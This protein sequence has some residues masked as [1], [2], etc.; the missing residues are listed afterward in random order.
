M[1]TYAVEIDPNTVDWDEFN[2]EMAKYN[3]ELSLYCDKVAEELGVNYMAACDIVYLRGR[4]RWTQEKED[5]LIKLA[6]EGK[7]LPFYFEDFDVPI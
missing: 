4:S 3:E 6:K 2:K 5:Y 7:E 1:I